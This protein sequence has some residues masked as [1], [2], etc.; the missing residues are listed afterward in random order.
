MDDAD[1]A[2]RFTELN[3]KTSLYASRKDEP[4]VV[5][6]GECLF[7]EAPVPAGRRWCDADCRDDWEKE[8]S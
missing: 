4:D 5:A 7:C 1:L 8:H 2:N 6:T 3:L